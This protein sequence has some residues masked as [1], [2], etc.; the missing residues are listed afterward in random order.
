[1]QVYIINIPSNR[2]I[3]TI[4]TTKYG[5]LIKAK[6]LLKIRII[7]PDYKEKANL[8]NALCSPFNQISIRK[9]NKHICIIKVLPR[10]R[11]TYIE[12]Q[13]SIERR[14]NVNSE[15]ICTRTLTDLSEQ[16]KFIEPKNELLFYSFYS[17]FVLKWIGNVLMSESEPAAA[18]IIV[19][20]MDILIFFNKWMR[21][22]YLSNIYKYN[23]SNYR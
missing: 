14:I 8:V 23:S 17:E 18:N 22:K 19:Y 10:S 6:S 7:I 21:M 20:W 13:E 11:W 5:N 2:K 15:P 3:W 4:I 16:F 12:V 9:V 1:M